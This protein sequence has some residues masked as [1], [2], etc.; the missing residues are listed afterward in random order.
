MNI[1]KKLIYILVSICV[2]VPFAAYSQARL[3]SKV[4]FVDLDRIVFE[5]A[6]RYIDGE[7]AKREKSLGL[8]RESP[9][10]KT[11]YE[12]EKNNADGERV[13]ENHASIASLKRDRNHLAKTGELR[14]NQLAEIV[15]KNILNAVRKTAEVE[16][17]SVVIDRS[18]NFVYGSQE[19]DLTERVL[20]RLF[21]DISGTADE[22]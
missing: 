16:G 1:E 21:R 20:Q 2:L 18:G 9:L 4:G 14:D 19:V 22:E 15:E 8:I 10:E 7:I 12:V 11:Q 13:G 3:L 17:F 5:Y 6:S